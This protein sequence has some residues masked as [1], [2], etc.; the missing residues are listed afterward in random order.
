MSADAM[1]EIRACIAFYDKRGWDWTEVVAYLASTS[2]GAWPLAKG[3][4]FRQT[5]RTAV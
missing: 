5:K 3:W 1:N 4:V 2:C